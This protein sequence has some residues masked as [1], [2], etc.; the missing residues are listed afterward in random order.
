VHRRTPVVGS[1]TTRAPEMPRSDDRRRMAKT[2]PDSVRSA[3][4]LASVTSRRLTA[5]PSSP[6]ATATMRANPGRDT[7]PEI[8]LRSALHRVGLRFRKDLRMVVGGE[9]IRPDIVFTR[10]HVAVFVD[11]CFWHGC[12][13]HGEMPAS[14]REFWEAKIGGTRARDQRQTAALESAGWMVLRVWEH[15]PVTE[16]VSRILSAVRRDAEAGRQPPLEG[17]RTADRTAKTGASRSFNESPSAGRPS[18]PC[19]SRP[20]S[21]DSDPRRMTPTLYTLA[22]R[23]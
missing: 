6:H 5:P 3:L 1:S 9:R 17:R 21:R 2:G 4:R 14:N 10:S 23:S 19:Q 7:R 20:T 18:G 22:P 15:E 8:A 13:E 11:G 12:A 16:A